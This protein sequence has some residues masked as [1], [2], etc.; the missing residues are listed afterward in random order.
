[1]SESSTDY[2]FG[3]VPSRRLGR[4][5]GIDLVPFKTCSYN[6]IYCQLGRT[7]CLTAERKEWVPADCVLEQVKRKLAGQVRA[8]VVTFSGSGEPTLHS[9]IGDIIRGIKAITEIPVV[10]LTNSSLLWQ[11]E[12]RKD[13]RAAD[14]V[15]PS[16]D[17]GDESTFSYVN[18]PHPDIS[19]NLM[20]EGLRAFREEYTGQFWLEVFLL[21]GVTAIEAEVRK[22]AAIV[23][24]LHPDRLQLNSVARPPAEEFAFAV[25]KERMIDLAA[26]FGQEAE[27]ISEDSH[28]FEQ[29]DFETCREDIRSLLLRRP[30]TIDDI[31]EGLGMHRDEVIKYVE[32]LSSEGQVMQRRQDLATFYWAVGGTAAKN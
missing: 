13:I 7:T 30:C 21:R 23:E 2:V 31:A 29:A 5:L 22:M 25:P 27:V 1:M 28:V 26:L 14:I 3:P 16:L 17:A 11:P 18:R 10:V 6:C 20:L 12:V 9:R 15:V 8:D 32:E 4:S 19:F 24:Q